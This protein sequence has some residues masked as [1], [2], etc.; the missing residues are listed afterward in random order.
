M[1]S[2][3]SPSHRLSPWWRSAAAATLALALL[4]A[5]AHGETS[6]YCRK[7]HARAV[8]DAALLFAPSLQLQGIKF[9]S[10]GI[11]DVGATTGDGYQLRGGIAFSPLDFYK[12]FRVLRA[13]DADCRQHEAVEG[14]Q[15]VLL[16]ADDVGR[17]AALRKQAEF[18]A[19]H[20]AEWLRIVADTEDR[21]ARHITPLLDAQEIRARHAE[22][23]RR[24]AQIDGEIERLAARDID[25]P[26]AGATRLASTATQAAM[27][28]EREMSHLRTL[29]AWSLTFTG[30]L[31]PQSG[32]LDYYGIVQLAFNVGGIARYGRESAY[33]AARDEELRT[34]RYE[35]QHEAR[36]FTDQLASA[37]RQARR[38]LAVVSTQMSSL[39]AIRAT[40]E[41]ADAAG[42]AN[43]LAIIGMDA[44]RIESDQVF[45][46]TLVDALSS[47]Q[48][49]EHGN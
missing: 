6:S 32:P 38:E 43:A 29:E 16:Q 40:L 9:P 42:A 17:L 10:S 49:Q 18:L 36:R 7:V 13:G 20:R 23:E 48:E 19:S 22:L 46:S 4:P 12:G 44:I 31:I 45:L 21:F 37:S 24:A 8:G 3:L 14:V 33:L 30:G 34:A 28:Y 11:V 15:R 35:V 26:A 1:P 41:H 27:S 5:R 2:A 47:L 39:G 25:A